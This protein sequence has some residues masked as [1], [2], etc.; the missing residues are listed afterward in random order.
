MYKTY[1]IKD[2]PQYTTNLKLNEKKKK[3]NKI[4]AKNLDRHLTKEDPQIATKHMKRCFTLYLIR[5]MQIKTTRRY[6]YTPSRM[7]S[8][9]N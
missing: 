4:W 5:K 3:N 6:H 8:L 7:T 1:L 2:F 9:E